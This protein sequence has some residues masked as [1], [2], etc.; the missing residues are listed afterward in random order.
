MELTLDEIR[1]F[2][3]CKTLNT[4]R[5][6]VKEIKA[7]LKLPENKKRILIVHLAKYEGLS[8]SEVKEIIKM[9]QKLLKN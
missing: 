5:D 6:R 4:A 7:G 8:V 9:Y 1:A 3:G 2:Y